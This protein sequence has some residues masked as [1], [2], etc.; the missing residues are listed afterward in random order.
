MINQ[1]KRLANAL[2]ERQERDSD[3]NRKLKKSMDF[4]FRRRMGRDDFLT[5]IFFLKYIYLKK[6]SE[7][8]LQL[9][10]NF[11]F[12][13]FAKTEKNKY[14][15][16]K[17]ID[18]IRFLYEHNPEFISLK[19]MFERDEGGEP[20]RMQKHIKNKSFETI[21]NAVNSKSNYNEPAEFAR[22][23]RNTYDVSKEFAGMASYYLRTEMSAELEKEIIGGIKKEMKNWGESVNIYDISFDNASLYLDIVKLCRENKK[24]ASFFFS[25]VNNNTPA[26]F[27]MKTWFL[28]YR[29]IEVKCLKDS[30]YR[31]QFKDE[32]SN[33]LKYDVIMA[34][35]IDDDSGD[36]TLF[37][38]D[39][40][41]VSLKTA[42]PGIEKRSEIQ[43]EEYVYYYLL[44]AMKDNGIMYMI[45]NFSFLSSK[46][47]YAIR[48]KIV[49]EGMLS[50][51][52]SI[53]GDVYS[54]ANV[55][56]VML[57]FNKKKDPIKGIHFSNFKR[58]V[59]LSKESLTVRDMQEL[60]SK[61][62][63]ETT[64]KE[65]KDNEYN[66]NVSVYVPDEKLSPVEKIEETVERLEKKM[67]S[68][69]DKI[70]D[71]SRQIRSMR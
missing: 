35:V 48:K 65:I 44:E 19:C 21:I 29:N 4:D 1:R 47:R 34:N 68:I 66:L 27:F 46:N 15:Y 28:G 32:K 40:S 3:F 18:E 22:F 7:I 8:N 10:P 60:Q 26:L 63:R 5:K 52:Y 33:L 31:E 45:D 62:G 70:R 6:E 64:A 11:D 9:N 16:K 51:V 49:E 25:G 69:S 59:S 39:E 24:K 38:D 43:K 23:L 12:L 67:D 37:I 42:V 53:Y 50:Q 13:K 55:D 14:I 61:T 2:N 57:V 58:F 20:E 36:R 41:V 56:P 17:I 71:L 54:R 30:W